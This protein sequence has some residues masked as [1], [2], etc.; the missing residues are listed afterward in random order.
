MAE[1]DQRIIRASDIAQYAYCA[2]SWWLGRI[3]KFP[4]ENL[5]QLAQGSERHFSHGRTVA[6]HQL[7]ARAGYLCLGG[8]MVI[9]LLLLIL[10][11][12]GQLF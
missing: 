1:A 11:L 2:R 8:A 5:G 4:P 10:A 6:A 9:A 7:A 3:C 12:C